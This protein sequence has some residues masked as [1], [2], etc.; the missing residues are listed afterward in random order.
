MRATA[1]AQPVESVPGVSLLKVRRVLHPTD[2]KPTSKNALRLAIALAQQ[3][4]AD[5]VLMH[6]LPPPTPIY[7]I[8]SPYR[9]E[10]EAELAALAQRVSK[11]GIT[12]KRILV[13]GSNPVP[14]NIARCAKFFNADVIVM[15]GGTRTGLAR[16]LT[17]SM[18]A[19]V[20]RR[21]PCPVLVVRD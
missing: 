2:L 21:A 20:I 15:A 5:L 17:G 7:E 8:D 10:A 3:Y 6:A 11:L 1:A 18:T 4:D 19:K 12:A 14:Q 13:K 9:T 16:F